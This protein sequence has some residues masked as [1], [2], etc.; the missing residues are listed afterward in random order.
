MT[1]NRFPRRGWQMD[2]AV[3]LGGKNVRVKKACKGAR[4]QREALA[5]E[6]AERDRLV[7]RGAMGEAPTFAAFRVEFLEN[8]ARANNKPSEY[9]TK[10]DV[11]AKH[12]GPAFDSMLL[13]EIQDE[14]VEAYKSA[15][16]LAGLKPKTINNH[17]AVLS[18]LLVTARRWKR[19]ASVPE[20]QR[21]KVP[22]AEFDFFTFDEA[23][24][25]AKHAGGYPCGDMIRFALNTGLRQGELIG[26]RVMDVLDGKILVRQSIVR[27]VKGTPKS[28]KPREVS[29]N[30]Y[31]Q[32]QLRLGCAAPPGTDA[33][34]F[35]LVFR[36]DDGFELSK[37]DC[38]WPLW[39][40]CKRAGLRRVGWHVLRHTFASH[41]AMRGVPIKSIQE[42]LGHSDIRQTMRYAHLS[43]D[44]KE[45]AVKLLET[46]YQT[47]RKGTRTVRTARK[48]A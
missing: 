24:E 44:V 3:R 41:L 6:R 46:G 23:R 26:L 15:K 10:R 11:L 1:V 29:L 16:L 28:H 22:E 13:D 42:L 45:D 34:V 19:I 21:L 5:M 48:D 36:G 8:Y 4:N 30:A 12:L 9:Q 47:A 31:A 20:I 33:P 17:L 39:M 37:G 27:G 14:Q 43:P 18:K 32:Q 40:A 2:F 25:L 35:R 7:N 38:K